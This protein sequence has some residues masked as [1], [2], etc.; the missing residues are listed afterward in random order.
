VYPLGT[1]SIGTRLFRFLACILVGVAAI[2]FVVWQWMIHPALR[3]GV[4][5]R[6]KET[7]RRAADQIEEFIEHRAQRLIQVSE[8]NRF[9]ELRPDEQRQALYRLLKLDPQIRE[10]AVADRAGQ[11]VVRVSR[12]R[13]YTDV[14]LVSVGH[15]P[16]Y[17]DPLMG[18]IHISPVYHASTAEPFLSI[19]VPIRLAGKQTWGSIVAEIGLKDLWK[20]VAD[21]QVGE[22]GLISVTDESGALIAHPDYSKV[23][24]RSNDTPH[25]SP[26]DIFAEFARGHDVTG[27]VIAGTAGTR[28]VVT[29]APVLKTRWVVFVQEPEEVAFG[30]IRLVE[31]SALVILGVAL[32]GMLA[33]SAFF[34]RRIAEPVGQLEAKSKL[35]AEGQLD[36]RL[37]IHT[38]DE[39]ERLANQ[40]NRMAA[41]L[42][43]ARDG[44]ES[45]VAERSREITALYT[46]MAPLSDKASLRELFEG[47]IERL[48]LA[49]GADAALVR[50]Y[51][52][53][54]RR[55]TCLAQQGFA[56]EFEGAVLRQ[57][58]AVA[59]VFASG[60]PI[61]SGD[62]QADGRIKRKLQVEVGLN[63]C[64]FLP[65]TVNH[66][67]RGILHLASKRTGYFTEEKREYL[68][69]IARLM[70]I[71]VENSELLHSSL[72]YAEQL[73][74]S[75][76]ELERSNRELQ[77]F[78]YVASH[79]LQEPLRM[80]RSYTG[81][82]A[83]RYQGKLDADA[84]EFIG[85]AVDG[86]R[87]MQELINDLLS[88][89]RVE[90]QGK[91]FAATDCEAVFAKTLANLE[92]AI[93]ESGAH[94]CH[95]PLPTVSADE[96]QLGQLFQNLIGNGIKYRREG[97][98]EI[99]VACKPA[100]RHWL[101]SVKDNG[102]GIEPQY[103]E[104][105][106]TIFQRLH[107][108]EQ[109]PGSGIGLAICKKIVERHGG[110]IW[111]E[112]ELGKGATFYFTIPVEMLRSPEGLEDRTA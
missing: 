53:E 23:L 89:S 105:I 25:W 54:A 37:E 29:A 42:K 8:V 101:F 40:F 30:A 24:M 104:R 86:A 44:L 74:Q 71:V 1:K 16:Q 85:Y 99:H 46:A 92:L 106:F 36:Q 102:I 32:F 48:I 64:A 38:G 34:S 88:Y 26:R 79:D 107:T 14:D 78:A 49:T 10:I 27:R 62:I 65:L 81:L 61:I 96:V 93:Q 13:V 91:E 47:I 111:V 28:W 12:E 87:R 57:G 39:I 2:F 31:L 94:V 84:D 58:S 110:K 90:T 98:L 17:R 68:M 66:R 7:A 76:R 63:S 41:A 33:V 56:A 45:R 18:N 22:S 55:F 100:G 15:L 51:D 108:K 83:R 73:Q 70:G 72:R 6:Q 75:N 9:W 5:E 52:S 112:S 50:I 97:P 103:H 21:I 3:R 59:Q 43:E 19:G 95:K 77:Q 69:A 109:Y 67:T 35:V 60:E 82:L 80:V 20:S 4:F 11:L